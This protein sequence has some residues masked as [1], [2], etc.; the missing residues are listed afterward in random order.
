MHVCV[1]QDRQ[2]N[3]GHHLAEQSLKVSEAE[4]TLLDESAVR[5]LQEIGKLVPN[6]T[7]M[8]GI[9]AVRLSMV[10]ALGAY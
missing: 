1:K 5:Y 4:P 10:F 2:D 3:A 7:T 6:A 9:K 8:Q